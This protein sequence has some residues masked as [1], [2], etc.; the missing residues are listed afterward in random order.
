M[1]LV[2]DGSVLRNTGVRGELPWVLLAA[3]GH[4][5]HDEVVEG[6]TR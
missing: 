1:E 2:A 5:M 3:V 6:A 4:L